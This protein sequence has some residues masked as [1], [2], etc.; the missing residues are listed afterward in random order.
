MFGQPA[1]QPASQPASG[2]SPASQPAKPASPASPESPDSPEKHSQPIRLNDGF[3]FRVF[4]W[5]FRS[6]FAKSKMRR[7]PVCKRMFCPWQRN[8][9]LECGIWWLR[10]EYSSTFFAFYWHFQRMGWLGWA[11]LAGTGLNQFIIFT[12]GLAEQW[13]WPVNGWTE[14][15]FSRSFDD[16]GDFKHISLNQCCIHKRNYYVQQYSNQ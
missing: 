4:H 3:D 10:A 15:V 14:V 9:A 1:G 7:W 5:G 2:A 8:A 16:F 13:A 6:S 12:I 11:G